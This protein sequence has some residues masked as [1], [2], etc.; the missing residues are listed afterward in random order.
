MNITFSNNNIDI[1]NI[2]NH[3]LSKYNNLKEKY[4]LYKIRN[5]MFHKKSHFTSIFIEYLIWDDNQE[6]LFE[7]YSYKYSHKNIPIFIKFQFPK[8]YLL[9][10]REETGRAIISKNIEKKRK[11]FLCISEKTKY[12]TDKGK[13]ISKKYGNILPYDLSDN[14]IKNSNYDSIK[15]KEY[16][17]E[18]ESTI[19]NVNANN[20]ISMSL[21]LKIN[22]NYDNQILNKNIGFVKGKNG[23]NDMEL[24]N[25]LNY[26]KKVN[27][28]PIYESKKSKIKNKFIYWEYI[29][30]KLKSKSKPNKDKE[31]D[32]ELSIKN[33]KEKKEKNKIN[34]F[35]NKTKNISTNTTRY[36]Q[37]ESLLLQK[38]KKDN[39]QN[40]NIILINKYYE[41]N[42]K[43]NSTKTNSYNNK[44][45]KIKS[46]NRKSKNSPKE[47][48]YKF[49]DQVS[50]IIFN[51]E[52]RILTLYESKDKNRENKD[53]MTECSSKYVS[54]IQNKK[55]IITNSEKSTKII[56]CNNSKEKYDYENKNKKANN[57]M[58]KKG[59]KYWEISQQNEKSKLLIIFKK[60]N[61]FKKE[62]SLEN[63]NS[64]LS[65]KLLHNQFSQKKNK[66]I[67]FIK[68]KVTNNINMFH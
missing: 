12:S 30:N 39:K 20:D 42:D 4:Y 32:K 9:I 56:N 22:K 61:F 23:K 43:T 65:N 1:R 54:K 38:N 27:T 29:N 17:N 11:L 66:K 35:D 48:N 21:D 60:D 49:S 52:K 34:S 59:L 40:N 36:F 53:N 62:S 15:E 26:M 45:Y 14:K 63:K 5:L 33:K 2:I 19:D 16:F 31:K 50:H 28:R 8:D 3:N 64:N 6:F 7:L 25:M 37:K 18:S 55:I 51:P 67:I 13:N 58:T 68:D 41:P 24:L 44:S 47:E 10:L 57:I 46:R